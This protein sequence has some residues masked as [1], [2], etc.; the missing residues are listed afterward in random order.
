[1]FIIMLT[2]IF[3]KIF[4]EEYKIFQDSSLIT[5]YMFK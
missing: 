5:K 2:N 4:I 3:N 1:M